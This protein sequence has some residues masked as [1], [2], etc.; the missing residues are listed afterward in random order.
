MKFANIIV[1]ISL[2]KLDRTFQYRIPEELQDILKEGMQVRVPFGNG[3]RILTGYVLELTDNCEWDEEKLKPIL[4]LAEK[5]IR[6]EGQLIAL[7][8]WMRRT[9]G[10]TMNQALKTVLPVKRSVQEKISRKVRLAV[11]REEAEAVLAEMERKH[12]TARV[13][14]L[15]ALLEQPGLDYAEAQK[16]LGLTAATARKLTELGLIRIESDTIFRNPIRP[17]EVQ[18]HPFALYP[19]QQAIV[20]DV[21]ARAAA[22]DLRPSLIH[23]VTGS[24]KTE[25]YMEL[26]AS[27]LEQ[28]KEA[29]VLIPEIALTFQ[30]VLRFYRRFG[31][32]VSIIH[33]KLSAGERYDQFERARRGGVKVMIGPRSALFTPFSHLGVIV[34]DEEHE[35]SYK[36]E[37]APRYH[38]REAAVER[39]R[40]CGA[41][42]VLGSATPSVD[43]YERAREGVYQLYELPLRIENRA[44]PETEVVDLREELRMGNRS[45]FSARLKE[46]ME[47]R[48]RKGGQIMLFLN[49]RGYAGFVSCR[50]CGHVIKCPHCDVSLSL[51]H[52][53]RMVCHYCGYQTQAPKKCPSCGSVYI[54]AFRAGTQQV[55]EAAAKAFP[56]ARI[57]RMDF[58]TTRQK[59]GHERILE[60][61]SRKQADILVGTQMIVKGHDFPGVTLV[62]VLAADLSLYAGDYRAAE[63]TFQLLVQAAGRAGRGDTPGV[64]VIQTYSP[65]H[66]SIETAAA[67][68]YQAFFEK[69]MAFRR[70]MNYP[71][72]AHLMALYLMSED[73]EALN[74][75]AERLKVLAA[76]H[77]R[78]EIALI[79][80]SDPG[81]SKLKD[82]Y[83]KVLYLKCT[84]IAYLTE[85][86]EWLEA[87]LPKEKLLSTFNIQFDMDPVNPF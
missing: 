37:N 29:I 42:V 8:A 22:G 84:E 6:L 2:E 43:S 17:S 1:D 87:E 51:H 65:D 52:G 40:M 75:G 3:G 83:R 13:R 18:A 59:G 34:I 74:R 25:V 30:T 5:G 79:G 27:V 47:E 15:K 60:A 23:G 24:G 50:A 39:A 9:Y 81:L 14:I 4:G 72:A 44:M 28:E 86:K 11:P 63:R 21:A 57:L 36:S 71:P 85:W 68:D 26:I 31:D 12:Q 46:L 61:F 70:M 32:Q 55:A 10:S 54:G 66:Y 80:P 67:Q 69:E 41:F 35:G 77:T 16:A 76:A 64:A 56:G 7:A 49:R 45:V 73:E 82:V 38:A 48:L 20:D 53:G 19:A 58:D 62:G 33:S 78:K